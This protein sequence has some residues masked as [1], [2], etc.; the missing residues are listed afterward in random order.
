M[1][2]EVRAEL[3]K[4]QAAEKRKAAAEGRSNQVAELAAQVKKLTERK[5]REYR[6][7]TKFMW[8]DGDDE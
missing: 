1:G 6:P 7:I 3:G 2:A 4:L 5:P 8:G